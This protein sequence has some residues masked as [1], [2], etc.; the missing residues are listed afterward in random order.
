MDRP[1]FLDPTGRRLGALR[2]TGRLAGAGLAGYLLLVVASLVAPPG[3]DR[4]QVPGVGDVVPAQR[5][6]EIVTSDG[7]EADAA[8]AV[9]DARRA[10]ARPISGPTGRT[11]GAAP[12]RGDGGRG[13]AATPGPATPQPIAPPTAT[14]VKGKP[15]APPGQSGPTPGRATSKPTLK[16]KPSNPGNGR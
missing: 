12:G 14:P 15:T 8:A 6:P 9:D 7:E 5:A 4:L 11:G 13:P 2:L 16:P 10:G 1:V 3:L